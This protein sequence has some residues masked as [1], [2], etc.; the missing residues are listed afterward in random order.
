MIV[1]DTSA[2]VAILG[3]ETERRLFN[4][5]IEE[6]GSIT[7]STAN[8]LETRIVLYSRSGD[9]AILAVDSFM[10]KSKMVV[11]TITEALG[12]LAFQ[13]YRRYGKGTSHP[14]ALNY[15]DCFSYALAK[16]LNAPLLYKGNDFIH[17][18]VISAYD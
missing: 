8:L 16:S 10:L 1:I 7:I 14:A 18:D 3:N 4:E 12:D 9:N 17:T 13:A 2:L 11:A 15:G 5:I 6:A